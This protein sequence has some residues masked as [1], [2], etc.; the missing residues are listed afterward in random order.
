MQ[1]VGSDA[2]ATIPGITEECVLE[3]LLELV[4]ACALGLL[5]PEKVP[6]AIKAGGIEPS[7][8]QTDLPHLI[9]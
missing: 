4:T 9:E 5:Q 1:D 3:F 6:E 8:T 7:R 2:G